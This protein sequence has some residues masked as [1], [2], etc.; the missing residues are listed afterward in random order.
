MAK[1]PEIRLRDPRPLRGPRTAPVRGHK[2][3]FARKPPRRGRQGRAASQLRGQTAGRPFNAQG[4][5]GT[6]RQ[7]APLP[8]PR[9][10]AAVRVRCP[11]KGTAGSVGGA[12]AMLGHGAAQ[13]KR[14]LQ[15]DVPPAGSAGI[16]DKARGRG[17]QRISQCGGKADTRGP[18]RVAQVRGQRRPRH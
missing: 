15:C 10:P 17:Q 12:I 4:G 1:N 13:K 5:H 18:H 16:R 7:A 2:I 8:A 14:G 9:L 11:R 3:G 6:Q